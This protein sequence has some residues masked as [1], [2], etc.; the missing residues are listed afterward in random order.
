MALVGL[1]A[2]P[3]H[4]LPRPSRCCWSHAGS[5][6]P[7]SGQPCSPAATTASELVCLAGQLPTRLRSEEVLI[8][9]TLDH[10][11]SL[12]LLPWFLRNPRRCDCQ[13]CRAVVP[14]G[15]DEVLA[16]EKATL[17]SARGV[18]ERGAEPER[19]KE[20]QSGLESRG[21]LPLG[22]GLAGLQGLHHLGEEREDV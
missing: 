5:H 10:Q 22:S 14:G 1:M 11:E 13:L 18:Q 19:A 6:D 4:H 12:G 16:L 2:G 20:R 17:V 15:T 21:G 8:L 9:Q 3:C 7:H